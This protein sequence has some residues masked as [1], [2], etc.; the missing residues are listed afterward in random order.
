[1]L[2]HSSACSLLLQQIGAQIATAVVEGEPT[3]QL[4]VAQLCSSRTVALGTKSCDHGA[5]Q[6]DCVQTLWLCHT[7]CVT[8]VVPC[9]S[10]LRCSVQGQCYFV[11]LQP[12]S[13]SAG[14]HQQKHHPAV[15]KHSMSDSCGSFVTLSVVLVCGSC[16]LSGTFMQITDYACCQTLILTV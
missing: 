3:C 2:Y 5:A 13:P 15:A 4:R 16:Q 8:W 10:V 11:G 14:M 1:M 7:T 9:G 12:L 6:K